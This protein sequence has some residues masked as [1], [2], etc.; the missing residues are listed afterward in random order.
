[1]TRINEIKYQPVKQ[2]YF[3]QRQLRRYAGPWSLFALGI[4]TVVVGEFS[5]WSPGLLEGGFGGFLVATIMVTVMCVAFCMSQAELATI[6]PFTGGGYAYVRAALGPAWGAFAAFT[7][8]VCYV[9]LAAVICIN[10]ADALGPVL[11]WALN[12]AEIPAPVIWLLL[13]ALFVAVNCHGARLTFVIIIAT[14]LAA[15]VVLV[16]YLAAL[17]DGFN[18]ALALDIPKGEVG[19]AWLPNGLS[20]IAWAI[21]FAIWFY[22]GIGA[23]PLAAEESERPKKHMP[24]ALIGGMAV[25]AILSF[26]VLVLNSGVAPG[27]QAI[28]KSSL[29]L[30]LAMT[31]RVHGADSAVLLALLSLTGGIASFH[32]MIYVYGRAI[33]AASR[34]GYLP[35]WLSLTH[36]RRATPQRAL[37]VGAAIGYII[38]VVITFGPDNALKHAAAGGHEEQLEGILVNMSAFAALISYIVQMVAY[39]VLARDYPT[40]S[41]PYRS[42]AGST[43]AMTALVTASA[44]TILMFFNPGFRPGLYGVAAVLMLGMAYFFLRARNHLIGSPEEAYAVRSVASLDR[45]RRAAEAGDAPASDSAE[46]GA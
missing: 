33:F 13:Y 30:L 45:E 12:G 2:N 32:A 22:V 26:A 39:L 3:E 17:Y 18:L 42:L 16:G 36:P 21:P 4:G 19:S 9:L 44:A 41:R 24:R 15:C 14:T 46:K 6:M 1:M 20:G 28:G 40:L 29:P 34:A 11:T 23:V 37:V 43:G 8:V 27:G 10:I 35:A 25:L 7:Q 31:T 38:A 5:G